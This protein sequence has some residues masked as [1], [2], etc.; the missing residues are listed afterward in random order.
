MRKGEFTVSYLPQGTEPPTASSEGETGEGSQA[1]GSQGEGEGSQ[2][3]GSQEEEGE[4]EGEPAVEEV[5]C[6]SFF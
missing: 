6:C 3:D 4:G 5:S 2:E 1:E